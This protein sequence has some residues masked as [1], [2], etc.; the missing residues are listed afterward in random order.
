VPFVSAN[1]VGPRQTHGVGYN[2]V[3]RL[4]KDSTRLSILGDG[5]QSKSYIHVEDVIAAG[6]YVTVREIAD[7][8]CE[9]LDIAGKVPYEF[10]G[11]RG[12]WKGDVPIVRLNTDR[13]KS[14]GWRCRRNTRQ[15][16]ADSIAAML[17]DVRSG[18]IS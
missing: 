5:N 4:S 6:D 15:A 8:A 10:S 12:G 3:R 1:V 11:G 7:I 17:R 14:L 2:F 13:I 18:R 9:A 16:M